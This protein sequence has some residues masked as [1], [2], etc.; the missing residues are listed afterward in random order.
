MGP[1]PLCPFPTLRQALTIVA[2]ADARLVERK[3]VLLHVIEGLLNKFRH[4]LSPYI[5]TM[6]PHIEELLDAYA[7][8]D[9]EDVGLWTLLMGVLAKSF[10][11]DDGG[12]SFSSSPDGFPTIRFPSA[13]LLLTHCSLSRSA[14]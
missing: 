1:G 3:T 13:H 9:I 14:V 11:V 7:D 5:G 4:L 12:G 10:E 2:I 6:M 8:G